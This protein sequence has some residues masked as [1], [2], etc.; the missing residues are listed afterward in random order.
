MHGECVCTDEFIF[1]TTKLKKRP[2]ARFEL[3]PKTMCWIVVQHSTAV[4]VE[5]LFLSNGNQVRNDE[6][7]SGPILIKKTHHQ[8]SNQPEKN[9][10]EQT[11][12]AFM[13]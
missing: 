2:S 6:F 8:D 7:I 9:C 11:N 3:T 12:D 13:V 10:I 1:G 4:A 5:Q